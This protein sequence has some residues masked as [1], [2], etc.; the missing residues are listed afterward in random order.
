M[1]QIERFELLAAVEKVPAFCNTI[2]HNVVAAYVGG[3]LLILKVGEIYLELCE[4][5][6]RSAKPFEHRLQNISAVLHD[7]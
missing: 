1:H 2:K 6:T 7:E 4:Q 5:F 3:G